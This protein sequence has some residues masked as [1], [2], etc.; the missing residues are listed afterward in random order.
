MYDPATYVASRKLSIAGLVVFS[1]LCL[2]SHGAL[3][4][5]F[6]VGV[7]MSLTGLLMARNHA[8]CPHC[9]EVV[10]EYFAVRC[11]HCAYELP[12]LAVLAPEDAPPPETSPM[13]IP[14]ASPQLQSQVRQIATLRGTRTRFP[15][16]MVIVPPPEAK[17]AVEPQ[18][19][20]AAKSS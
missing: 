6:A 10:K 4:A 12:R 11:P 1:L 3:T 20:S 15:R 8:Q 19:R 16:R 14:A 13:V 2:L 18:A 17:P 9:G 5:L 7:G